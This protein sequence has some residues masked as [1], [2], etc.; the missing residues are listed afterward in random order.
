MRHGD[1]QI[2]KLDNEIIP[3]GFAPVAGDVITLAEGEVTG[4]SHHIQETDNAVLYRNPEALYSLLHV[5]KTAE[6]QHQEHKTLELVPGLYRVS[7]KRQY[8]EDEIG[9]ANV[10]D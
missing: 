10:V 2:D 6:L 3:P 7:I 4:H 1:V 8:S 9:W 5:Q